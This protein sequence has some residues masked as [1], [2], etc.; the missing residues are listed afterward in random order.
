MARPDISAL[1][2]VPPGEAV[3]LASVDPAATPG[4]TG[5]KAKARRQVAALGPRLAELQTRLHAAATAGAADRVLLV[6]QG[7]DC[8]GKDGVG[9]HVVSLFEPMWVRYATF[10][11]PT[12]EELRHDFLWRIRRHLP[13][14][15]EIGVFNRS[16]YEDV[17][18][19]AVHN[20]VPRRTWRKRYD[21]INRFEQRLAGDGVR[22]VKVMLHISPQEQLDRL[23]ARLADPDKRWKYNPQDVDERHYHEQYVT[24]TEAA[25]ARCN[26]PVAP[27]HLVPA[28]HKW[29]RDWAVAHLLLDALGEIGPKYP[30]PGF[31][32]A[33]EQARLDAE[34]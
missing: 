17:L 26:T 21:A 10:V 12:A 2:R 23:R 29:Y 16:H 19:V 25:L 24:A 31:D 7:T 34:G 4:F 15:G 13:A 3:D 22:F 6:L 33:A 30:L 18:I 9:R 8:S 14:A 20:L 32:L 1:L 27:W 28:D 11:K 5:G